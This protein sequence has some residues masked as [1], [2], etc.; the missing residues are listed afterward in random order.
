MLFARRLLALFI[1]VAATLAASE[2]LVRL[3]HA[4]VPAPANSPYIPDPG[5]GFRLRPDL[6]SASLRNEDERV[7]SLGFRDREHSIEKPPGTCR[8][9]GIGDSF[10]YGDV[11]LKDNFLQ[12]TESELADRLAEQW[13]SVEMV[14]MGLGGYSPE[15]ALGL[16]RATAL[17]LSP[18]LITLSFFVGNDVIGIPIRGRV[19]RG[20]MYFIGSSRPVLN[21]LRKLRIFQ[22]AE[23]AI[24]ESGSILAQRQ[25]TEG[26][27]TWA[28]VETRN[29]DEKEAAIWSYT[30]EDFVTIQSR[31]LPVFLGHPHRR[32][33]ELWEEAEGY[34][35][36]FDR[37]CREAE[38]PW[39]LHLVPSEVQ[40]DPEIRRL[41]L[42]ALSLPEEAYDFDAPQRRL[43]DFAEAH[44]ITIADPLP[45]LRAEHSRDDRLYI[46]NNTHWNVK[47][48]RLAGE[49]LAAAVEAELAADG[50]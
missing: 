1:V 47:G 18:D 35:L 24:R 37:L 27:D 7:N 9:L 3:F 5:A 4:A 49:I 44:G 26:Q 31:R 45:Q 43:H 2:G 23:K 25:L 36:E 12:I 28:E 17:D 10:V 39:I 46:P 20:R 48:N 21:V 40:V 13:P 19:H 50:R 33:L 42:E 14:M 15:N 8:I 16:L 32:T 34:L 22:L 6:P 30:W 41:V 38:V 29:A 11:R